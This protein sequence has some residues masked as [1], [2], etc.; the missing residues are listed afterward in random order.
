MRL[1]ND[2]WNGN[3]WL[4]VTLEG[5]PP[6]HRDG[7]AS[8]VYVTTDGVTQMRELHAS[9]N[10]VVQEPSRI[11]HFGVGDVTIIDEVRA[12]WANGQTSVLKNIPSDQQISISNK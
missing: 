5:Y 8:R 6:L 3:H 7:I 9:T 12:K 1:R 11:A 2:T 4:K 10:Y